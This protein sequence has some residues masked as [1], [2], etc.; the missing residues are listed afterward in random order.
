MRIS[1]YIKYV[2][3]TLLL[4]FVGCN[5]EGDFSQNE[6]GHLYV[7]VLIAEETYKTE[8]DS[9]KVVLDSIYRLHNITEEQ[10]LSELEKYEYDKEKWDTLFSFAEKYLDTLR[11]IEDS[12]TAKKKASALQN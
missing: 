8:P 9:L 2:I 7:D 5:F 10:Y 3:F 12:A 4:F 1:D 11:A 6:I